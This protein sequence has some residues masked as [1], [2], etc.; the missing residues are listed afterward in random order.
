MTSTV[1]RHPGASADP[2]ATRLAL[3]VASTLF[4]PVTR[5]PEVAPAAAPRRVARGRRATVRG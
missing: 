5:A 1:H 2:A 3:A 4:P